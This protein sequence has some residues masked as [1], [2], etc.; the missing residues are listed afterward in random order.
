MQQRRAWRPALGAKDGQ[1]SRCRCR[2]RRCSRSRR[3][4]RCPLAA[5]QLT[6]ALLLAF[7]EQQHQ[8]QARHLWQ[9]PL[10]FRWPKC[11]PT[12]GRRQGP[13]CLLCLL[14]CPRWQQVWA[15][16]V[17]LGQQLQTGERPLAIRCG[18][19][20]SYGR[21]LGETSCPQQGRQLQARRTWRRRHDS[22]QLLAA[23]AG[24]SMLQRMRRLGWLA[25]EASTL[26]GRRAGLS[27]WRASAG[28]LGVLEGWTLGSRENWLAG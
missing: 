9:H 6:K 19:W 27:A 18:G 16:Q 8:D 15:Q 12:I 4:G 21:P 11:Q 26:Q 25:R 1:C 23:C 13:A 22:E 20:R 7:Q 28:W 24:T 17:C 2:R 3:S 5:P 10:H 14:R